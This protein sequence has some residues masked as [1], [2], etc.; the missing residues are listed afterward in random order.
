MAAITTVRTSTQDDSQ[1][2]ENI[3]NFSGI[4]CFCMGYG[5]GADRIGVNS[6]T[7]ELN[8]S[9]Q[10]FLPRIFY[11]GFCFLNRAFR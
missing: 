7:P 4:L 11:W 9:A 10:R 2:Y 8:P 3:V 1:R 5:E 6:L